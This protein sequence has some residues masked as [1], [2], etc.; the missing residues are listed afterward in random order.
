[1]RVIRNNTGNRLVEET[2]KVWEIQCEH[3]KS[4]LEIT[5]EDTHVG[6]L[7]CM[8][9][10]CPCCGKESYVH[11]LDGI[12][13]TIDNIEFPTHFHRT[14]S[15]HGDAKEISAVEIK[16]DIRRGIEYLR[17]NQDELDWF[18]EHGD[19]Y[20]TV[21]K[22]PGDEEYWVVITKDFYH[23]YISFDKEDY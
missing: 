9:I 2:P 19:L 18:T 17:K 21:R 22:Y 8:Y 3:C 11:L 6:A 7:G 23:T 12:D 14:S 20:L 16:Q 1:M 15:E 13:L 4:E 10:T 5:E